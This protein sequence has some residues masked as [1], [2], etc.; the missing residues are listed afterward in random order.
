MSGFAVEMGSC[1]ALGTGKAAAQLR[2]LS[3]EKH[4]ALMAIVHPKARPQ[5][6]LPCLTLGA[7]I[8][9]LSSAL[10]VLL[11]PGDLPA[12]R[13]IYTLQLA[14]GSRGWQGGWGRADLTVPI[15]ALQAHTHGLWR[16]LG[17]TGPSGEGRVCMCVERQPLPGTETGPC[18]SQGTRSPGRSRPVTQQ[19]PGGVSAAKREG[20]GRDA[21]G[22]AFCH[23]L[24]GPGLPAAQRERERLPRQPA[25]FAQQ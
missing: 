7:G 4:G 5:H 18:W 8:W 6:A 11:C 22:P 2:S 9:C 3:L 19:R 15:G 13:P 24:V 20:Q 12:S 17:C 16:L 21:P 10:C 25:S 14:T 1:P 23:C